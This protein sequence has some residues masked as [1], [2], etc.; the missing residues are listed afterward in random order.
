MFSLFLIPIVQ[1][2]MEADPIHKILFNPFLQTRE[3]PK[4]LDGK[5]SRSAGIKLRASGTVTCSSNGPTWI[6]LFAGYS[7]TINF[8]SN[9]ELVGYPQFFN[10]HV[11]NGGNR[12]AIHSLR[13]V[14]AGVRLSLMN[15][16][17]ESE[18][19]WE[20]VRIPVTEEDFESN[21]PDVGHLNVLNVMAGD[22]DL[23]SHVSYVRGD[24]K[25]VHNYMFKLNSMD[26]E[27]QFKKIA[28]ATPDQYNTNGWHFDQAF[29]A[30][31]IKITGRRD[32]GTPSVVMYDSVSNQEVIYNENTNVARL[33]TTTKRSDV[34]QDVL[35]LS[36]L[37][38][39]ATF[40]PVK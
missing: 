37:D 6:C 31:L 14:S 28:N 1:Y 10:G 40:L 38:Q 19:L 35:A 2:T 39:S 36:V 33:M 25:D 18:G 9:V 11:E 12:A 3:Q 5:V 27:H 22:H 16:S 20:S 15:N 29:D 32:A 21:N 8:A 34:F 4:L 17:E 30:V 13:V 24:L 26:T 7:H 23:S